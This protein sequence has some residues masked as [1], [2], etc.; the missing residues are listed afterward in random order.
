MLFGSRKPKNYFKV[1]INFFWPKTGIKRA[2]KY[3]RYRFIRLP[4]SSYSI[5]AGFACGVAV[6]FT[7]LIG[8]HFVGAAFFAWLIGG[9]LIASAIGT[10]IGNPWT[11][12]LIWFWIL[13][14]GRWV[15]GD[16]SNNIDTDLEITN[17]SITNNVNEVLIPMLIGGLIMAPVTWFASYYPTKYLIVSYR[18]ARKIRIDKKKK[19]NK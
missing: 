9:N 3:S 4:G 2:V 6:S 12:P 19:I 11:F 18:A 5:A 13:N 8:F 17:S 1:I 7:P 10:A 15:I 14:L 16:F